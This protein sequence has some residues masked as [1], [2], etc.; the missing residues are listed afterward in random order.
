MPA[1]T[2]GEFVSRV[3]NM[4]KAV[5]QDAFLTDRFLF[6]LI[7][8]HARWLMKREDSK[9][10]LMRFSSV[11]QSIDYFELKEID[12]VEAHCTGIK[13]D[14]VIKRTCEK[15]PTFMQGYYGPLIRAV[16]S[17]D[18]S[19][20]LQPTNPSTYL[21]LSNSKSFKYNKTKYY[22]Y[23]NDYLYFPNL[24]W[25][26]IRIEGIFE[27]DISKFNCDTCDDC[28]L[29]QDQLFNVPDYLHAEIES[30]VMK[31]LSVM[32]QVPSDIDVNKQNVFR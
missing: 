6:S 17:I 1:V 25:E 14:C 12:K 5:K 15:V 20:Q 18:G 29:R 24:E 21:S 8:K 10:K 22:W 4:I 9:N 30:N 2:I 3:R 26:A 11:M 31:D 13:S 16:T 28:V 27:D 7:S 23:L 19:E 32:I